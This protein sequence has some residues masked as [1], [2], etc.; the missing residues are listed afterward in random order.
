MLTNLSEDLKYSI[1]AQYCIY[2]PCIEKKYELRVFIIDDSAY[3]VSIQTEPGTLS[4]LDWRR[5]QGT[6]DVQFERCEVDHV[7]KE[8]CM[9][10]MRAM[11]LRSASFDFIVDKQNNIHF[12]ELNQAGN[13]LWMD[14]AFSN[15]KFEVGEAFA[16]A[17]LNP[18]SKE[19]NL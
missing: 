4:S 11:K 10:M 3:T 5:G 8:Q 14:Y 15:E 1:E 9:S 6:S 17:L 18:P 13:F 19:V 16:V 7:I 2:Q 12:L